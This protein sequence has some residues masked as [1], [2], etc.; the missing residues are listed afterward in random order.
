ME[1]N[2]NEL[3]MEAKMA[4]K[5][6]TQTYVSL[7][8]IKEF[9]ECFSDIMIDT[10][11]DMG[12]MRYANIGNIVDYVTHNANTTCNHG[13]DATFLPKDKEVTFDIKIIKRYNNEGSS[14][15]ITNLGTVTW[16]NQV[17]TGSD[18]NNE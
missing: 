9:G 15:D 2:K 1:T 10:K 16:T 7:R 8:N 11:E 17:V 4:T 14:S 3:E 13:C 12:S 6:L 18:L 5:E